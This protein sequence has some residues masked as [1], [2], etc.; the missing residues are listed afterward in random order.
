MAPAINGFGYSLSGGWYNTAKV[1][2]LGGFD[3]T[4]LGNVVLVP[5]ASQTFNI[6]ELK[7]EGFQVA[8]G[9]NNLSPTVA[10]NGAG[11]TLYFVDDNN[12]ID[13]PDG[14]NFK[15]VPSFTP[16]IGVGLFKETELIIRYLPKVNVADYQF[17]LWGV[18]VKHSIKQ[19]IPVLEK[20]P[21]FQ[22][23][24]VF[25]YTKFTSTYDKIS[26]MPSDIGWTTPGDLSVYNDQ[27]LDFDVSSFTGSILV[28]ANIPVL[29]VYGG[30]GFVSTKSTLALKGV[31]PFLGESGYTNTEKDELSYDIK[32]EDGGNVKPR[33]NIGLRIKLGVLTI[34]ADYTKVNYNLITTGIGISFR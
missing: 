24:G 6:E 2:K 30:L 13:L 25:G 23:S 27:S 22:L 28:G 15:W 32:D 12:T 4:L 17:G 9:S 14:A 10:G 7:L 33:L 29:A 31:Y 21:V 19:W 8:D 20:I 1:H 18:G 11:S 5:E 26:V 3:F 16:Q 34:H